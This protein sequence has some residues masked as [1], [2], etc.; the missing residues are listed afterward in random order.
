M[1]TI[2]I[3]KPSTIAKKLRKKLFSWYD[4]MQTLEDSLARQTC[5]KLLEVD[6]PDVRRMAFN[7]LMNDYTSSDPKLAKALEKHRDHVVGEIW[8]IDG[9]KTNEG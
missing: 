4:N 1:G 7:S 2:R 6:S 9:E 3:P 8:N 5:D